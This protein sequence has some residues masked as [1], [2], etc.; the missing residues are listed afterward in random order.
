[1]YS[2]TGPKTSSRCLY[3]MTFHNMTVFAVQA[4][5]F[6]TDVRNKMGFHKFFMEK[7]DAMWKRGKEMM[8]YILQRGGK[9][10]N[11]FQVATAIFF[12]F[13]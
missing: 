13:L 11:G 8:K 7:S 6:N 3:S 10:G 9:M 5:T 2:Y 1:M 12:S 4:S